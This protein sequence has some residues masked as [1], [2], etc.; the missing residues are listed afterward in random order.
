V[1]RADKEF[2]FGESRNEAREAHP[3][4][5]W[6]QAAKRIRPTRVIVI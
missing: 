1:V 3:L 5:L 4:R 2:T 6:Q